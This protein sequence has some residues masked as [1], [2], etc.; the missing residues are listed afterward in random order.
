MQTIPNVSNS[1]LVEVDGMLGNGSV[2]HCRACRWVA[3]DV[4]DQVKTLGM[5]VHRSDIT[6]PSA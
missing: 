4:T 6:K 3:E 2:Q 5:H 1:C